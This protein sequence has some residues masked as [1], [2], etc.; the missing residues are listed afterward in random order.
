MADSTVN[1]WKSPELAQAYLTGIRGAI[2][3]AGLQLD[4]M[5]RL[6][7]ASGRPRRRFLDLG[8]GD[9]V[10]AAALLGRYPDASGVLVDFSQ[11]MLDAAR[12]RLQSG[13]GHLAFLQADYGDPG[14]TALVES[15]GPFDAV[16]SGFSIHH[17][18]DARK[19]SLYAEIFNL[20]RPGG[21]FVN[22][23]HVAS[24]SPWV[25]TLFV[26]HF[27]DALY[28]YH[29]AQGGAKTRQQV[30][31]EQYHRPDKAANLLAPVEVQC[32]WLREIGFQD[33][34]CYEK[35]FELCVFGGRRP[36]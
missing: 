3:L 22:V 7:E 35:L 4:V 15:E 26:E 33:V 20:L 2:P 10:L 18:P 29:V 16:V 12:A 5:L 24:A 19:R 21:V 28:A 30:A 25:E 27:V 17:Q 34:D 11:P 14:W 8:C 9:G 23:E 32:D 31:D 13:A 6:V 1:A 36:A